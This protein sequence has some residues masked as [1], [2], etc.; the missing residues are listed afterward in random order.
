VPSA[1]DSLDSP[2][3]FCRSALPPGPYVLDGPGRARPLGEQTVV[4]VSPD[5]RLGFGPLRRP[6]QDSPSEEAH[7]TDL[8]TGRIVSRLR[9]GVS[10]SAGFELVGW[11][12][13]RIVLTAGGGRLQLLRFGAGRLSHERTLRLPRDHFPGTF[14]PSFSAPV[15]ADAEGDSVVV[16]A[17]SE[18]RDTTKYR[19]IRTFLTCELRTARC[20]S[21]R[22]LRHGLSLALVYN[23]SGP[24][25]RTG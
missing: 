20:R 15:F 7:V 2:G 19:G 6:I 9:V 23:P 5:G 3:P 1:E 22:P 24:R 25:A 12:G 17:S 18:Y 8:A 4:A 21:G 13:D 11:T 16:R 10:T 14:G